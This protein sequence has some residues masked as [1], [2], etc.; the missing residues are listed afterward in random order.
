MADPAAHCAN[1]AESQAPPDATVVEGDHEALAAAERSRR[2]PSDLPSFDGFDTLGVLGSGSMGVVYRAFDRKRRQTVALKTLKGLSAESLLRFKQE[3]RTLAD[4]AHPHLVA[5]HELLGEGERWFFTMELVE[6]VDFLTWVRG[7][8][9][10]GPLPSE[11]HERLRA[12]LVQLGEGLVVLHNAGKLHRDIKPSNIRVAADG[13]AADGRLVLLDFGLAA[14]LDVTGHHENVRQVLLGTVAYMAP[15]QAAGRAVSPA[16]DWYSVGAMLFE[17][18]TG[19]LPY[20]GTV[21]E[22]LHNKQEQPA[23]HPQALYAELPADLAQ[24]CR[25]LL[26]RNP[27]NRPSG[28]EVLTRLGSAGA[29]G[30]RAP[31]QLLLGRESHLAA[32][33][34][35]Y[36]AVAAGSPQV[37]LVHGPSGMGK[38][39]LLRAFLRELAEMTAAVVL[40]GRCYEQE[41]VP[42]KAL[43]TL[44][45]ALSQHLGALPV[46][47]AGDLLPRDVFALARVFPVLHRVRPIASAPLRYADVLDRQQLRLRAFGALRE[48]LARLARRQPLVLCID[49]LQWGDVDSA[50]LL[51]ELLR[52][53]EPPVLLLVGSYRSEDAAGSAFLREFLG[54]AETN[55]WRTLAVEPL[56]D[57]Q[58]RAMAL[59]FLG[60]VDARTAHLADSVGRESG[61]SPFFVQELVEHLQ[62]DAGTQETWPASGIAL[63]AVVWRRVEA[64]PEP[65]RRPLELLAVAG[66]PVPAAV[67]GAP[68]AALTALRGGRLIRITTTPQHD[69]LE[70]Y[71][72]RIRET[73]ADRLS[74]ET[75]K[76]H[77]HLLAAGLEALGGADPEVLA[78][79]FQGAGDPQ[80]AGHYYEQA[81]D[82][83]AEALAFDRAAR[84]YRL[85]LELGA[86]GVEVRR[87]LQVRLAT[88]LANAG[89]GA[90]AAKE[91]LAAAEG[92][93]AAEA[94]DLR[95]L[96]AFQLLI[97][98]HIE[99][100]LAELRTVLEAVG[101]SLPATPRRAFWSLVWLRFRLWWRGLRFRERAE[102]EVSAD[103]IRRIDLCW[104]GSAGL[105][106]TDTIL[107]AVFQARSLL[108]ALDAGEP[109]RIARALAMEAG[110][111]A[112]A[113]DRTR[114]RSDRLL[115]IAEE[116]AERLKQPNARGMVALAKGFVPYLQG[117]FRVS[118]EW[119]DKASEIFR[120]QCTGVAW[121][122]DTAHTFALWSLICTGE[123]RELTRRWEVLTKEARERGD[124][125]A[126]TNLNTYIMATV[127]LAAD[128]PDTARAFLAQARGPWFDQ[129]F[130]VQHHNIVLAQTLID[131][132]EGKP[133]ESLRFLEE[134]WPR[135][136]A[137]LLI[138]LQQVRIDVLSLR[139]RYR[140]A[141]GVNGVMSDVR[142]LERER[143]PW[144]TA[145]AMLLRAGAAS[146]DER[147]RLLRV[148]AEQLDGVAMR[149][150]AAAAR[151]LLGEV[152]PADAAMAAEGVKD[153][154][155]MT[156][157]L[158]GVR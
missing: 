49:D 132:Y 88:A 148:A 22:V 154:G 70:T 46:G 59:A 12:S 91:Y 9:V 27:A 116:I 80:R 158:T 78:A 18:L 44:V 120:T 135:Y 24:L 23:P 92:A 55:A 73:V 126:L 45:D 99:Q 41:S 98:G 153:P 54:G 35:T 32:L 47:E 64:L 36:R 30:H 26:S 10:P 7:G 143:A 53:P 81:A 19:R 141:S 84:L 85:A 34:D 95:R 56:T 61:G 109:N 125:F 129:G 96:G 145:L 106:I 38:T 118:A 63:D 4:L 1:A 87:A 58:A 25:E 102:R 151:R 123:F 48:L 110:H 136:E 119:C 68:Q 111:L 147:T 107:G 42:Y 103:E 115:G 66:G 52:P 113:G 33:H 100:G 101:L 50:A 128:R 57:E 144:A 127:Q 83:A 77:H 90:E 114:R 112:T 51:G 82:R 5:F 20:T 140:L 117:H 31:G 75:R 94:L 15:E 69:L 8:K 62:S 72:D 139:G 71:H 93:A 28:G 3:F 6:G 65:A 21:P 134:Q 131:L 2:A 76:R 37:V 17:A 11:R 157:M 152:E 89:R 142:A 124:R 40:A 155:Q 137:S 146:G 138:R 122:T 97:S 39:A 43:D 121:E 86:K 13:V 149:M 60:R 14:E 156:W 133:A 130:H 150:H 16:S 79:H 105:S 67:I 108:L 29:A 104:A 74:P